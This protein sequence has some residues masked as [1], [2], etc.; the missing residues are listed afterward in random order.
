MR[1]LFL[2]FMKVIVGRADS[3]SVAPTDRQWAILS[4][5]C[6][7]QSLSGVGCFA[8]QRL[9]TAGALIPR[10]AYYEWQGL[11]TE[12]MMANEDMNRKCREVQDQ[13]AAAGFRS[14]ILKGQGVASYYP[15]ELSL[16]RESGDIDLWVDAPWDKVMEYVNGISPNREFDRKHTHLYKYDETVVEV[17]WWPS[18]PV[19]P[20]ARKALQAFYREQAPIQCA[21]ELTLADG[22][23]INAP[24][25]LFETVH[26]FMHIFSH[27]LYE[28]I[29]LRQFMDLYYVMLKLSEEERRKAYRLICR[30]GARRFAPV[31]MSIL[32]QVFGM[33]R[34]KLLCEPDPVR[35]ASLLDEIMSGGN[36]GHYKKENRVRNESTAHRFMRRFQRKLRLVEFNPLGVLCSPVGKL[37][38]ILWKRRACRRFGL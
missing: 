33:E 31:A 23:V 29:G 11:G 4:K 19:N 10:M 15:P 7:R 38:T 5:L 30:F 18:N 2:E 14:C 8:L 16:M 12:I 34:E 22:T 35:G 25:P 26:I 27:F 20:A 9:K 32:S 3:L 13:F 37:S 17:H 6:E 21:H 28:G 24:D 36:F 1:E